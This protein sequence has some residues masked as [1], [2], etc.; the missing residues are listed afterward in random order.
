MTRI[1]QETSRLS[2]EES[3]IEYPS[4]HPRGPLRVKIRVDGVTDR[5]QVR[6]NNE[7][8]F[9]IARMS[10]T[11]HICRSSLSDER[12]TRVAEEV[13][14]LLAVADGLGGAAGGE[15]ASAMSIASV[16][17]FVLNTF[18][19]FLNVSPDQKQELHAELSEALRRADHE[20]FRQARDDRS[21]AGMGTTLTMAYT[22]CGDLYIAHAGDS[23]A[24]LFRD[25]ALEQL[26][27]DHTYAQMLLEAGT[28]T[29]EQARN[30]R[31]QNVVTNV[32]GGPGEGV[33]VEIHK[34]ELQ[35][36]DVLLLCTDGLTKP[37][38]D[39]EIIA[40]LTASPSPS[41]ASAALLDR[42]LNAGGPDNVTLVV[43]RFEI[44][45]G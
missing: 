21:L 6:E 36:G 9:L 13:A 29:P 40:E 35:D 3:T 27:R 20:V 1:D 28:I 42:A 5:G 19:W 17:D 30:H 8:N 10:K 7:D 26:T 12:G 31:L 44:K 15:R 39:A 24:Y 16:E 18:K 41:E 2:I 37:V 33:F 43:A 22:I 25:G 14:H 45:R 23:R 4:T 11:M 32:I 34:A 38:S